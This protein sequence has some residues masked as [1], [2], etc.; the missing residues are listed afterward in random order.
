M[1]F[2][3]DEDDDEY[4]PYPGRR[5][6]WSSPM[7]PPSYSELLVALSRSRAQLDELQAQS[8]LGWVEVFH[9]LTGLPHVAEDWKERSLVQQCFSVDVFC[10]WSR[11]GGV[12]SAETYESRLE[13]TPGSVSRNHGCL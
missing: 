13:Q 10:V 2:G 8:N 1:N 11:R 9:A 5:M 7:P 3:N 4:D 12:H 6:N